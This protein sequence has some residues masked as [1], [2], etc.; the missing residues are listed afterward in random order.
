MEIPLLA[1][2]HHLSH[3]NHR[4]NMIGKI[5]K[6]ISG[7]YYVHVVGSGIYECR[8]KGLFRNIGVKPLVGDMVEIAVI[9]EDAMTGNVE[10]VLDRKNTL[11]RPSVANIDMALV[12]FAAAYPDPNL[13]L[14]DRFLITMSRQSIPTVIAFNKSELVSEEALKLL[15]S[16]YESSGYPVEIISVYEGKGIAE[17]KAHLRGKTTAI[18]GPSGVGKSSLINTLAPAAVMETGEVSKKIGRGK[19]TTRHTEIINIED[20]TYIMDT[21]GFSSLYVTDIKKEELW[22]Y[23]S[24]F[25]EFEPMCRFTG[26][27]HI[28]EPDCGV[29]SALDEGKISPVRYDNYTKLY[30]ECSDNESKKYR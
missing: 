22:Q 17:I 20:D 9:D 8:A 5:L 14:L 30:A 6:A 12:V 7:F 10:A 27:S 4:I 21:P 19:Q 15:K 1:H 28:S 16:S 18:A 13:N 29:K 24:E 3:L 23:Y 25:K 11:I 2:R 26:C